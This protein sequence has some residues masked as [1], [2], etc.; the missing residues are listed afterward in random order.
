M[1][2]TVRLSTP[3]L[4]KSEGFDAYECLGR[5]GSVAGLPELT[6]MLNKGLEGHTYPLMHESVHENVSVVFVLGLTI[7]PSV[8]TT[9]VGT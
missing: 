5:K 8:D 4:T 1:T 2:D 3:R 6:C 9:S 7:S